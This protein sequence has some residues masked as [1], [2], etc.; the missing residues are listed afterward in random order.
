M[1]H[2]VLEKAK[3]H[4][5]EVSFCGEMARKPL[6]ALALIGVGVRSLSVSASAIGPLKAMIRSLNIAELEKYMAYLLQSSEPSVRN[7]LQAYVQDHGI[8][9]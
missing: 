8:K 3:I 2:S 4:R 9:A 1:V 7:W 6:D 5:V